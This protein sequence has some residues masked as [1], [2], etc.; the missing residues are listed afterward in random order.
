[1]AANADRERECHKEWLFF[2]SLCAFVASAGP[3]TQAARFGVSEVDS[4]NSLAG[5]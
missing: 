1:M 5:S 3:I 4:C 2:G